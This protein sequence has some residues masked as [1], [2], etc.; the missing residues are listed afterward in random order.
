MTDPMTGSQAGA[1]GV[2]QDPTRTPAAAQTGA[3]APGAPGGTGQRP[4]RAGS[5]SLDIEERSI[6]DAL[7]DYVYKIRSGDPGRCRRSSA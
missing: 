5:F 4:E 7:R 1:G 2:T 3:G 6:R